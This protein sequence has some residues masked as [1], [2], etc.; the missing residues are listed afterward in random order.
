MSTTDSAPAP[1]PGA[2]PVTP[3]ESPATEVEAKPAS[4]QPA[5]KVVSES[6][7]E[8]EPTLAPTPTTKAENTE[9]EA[10]D[11]EPQNALTKKFTEQEWKALKE[12]RSLLPEIF[13]KAY[14]QKPG[15]KTT[16]ITIWGVT[17]DPNGTKDA[18]AS[19]VLMKWLRAR[20]LNV[21][22]AKT[23]MIATLRWRDEFKVEEAIKEEFPEDVYGK[24]GHIYGKDKEGRP[25]TY[26]LYGANPD[27][28]AVFGD[29]QRFLRWRIALMEKGIK[30]IDFETVDQM[31]QVHDYEGV[32]FNS[33]D[34]NSKAAA[35]EASNI[36]QN[37]YPEF[38][39]RKFF[40]NVPTFLS[41]IF[42]LFKPILSAE[43]LAKMKVVGSGPHAIGKE[44]LPL[45]NPDQ[46]PQR[47]GGDVTDA[48]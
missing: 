42:W 44:L 16:A 43:T 30:Q 9:G 20:K 27:L 21:S 38:L 8:P 14:D 31:I 22:E 2:A 46:L 34:A 28:K 26:N 15:A 48:W 33:R 23:M 37:H 39:A 29:V 47:Y 24:L 11:E 35:A 25:L 36:F 6:A 1:Q 10:D 12:F 3:T 32:G 18:K 45:V 5:P 4:P 7:P 40:V 17:L 19:V 41:W 13:D